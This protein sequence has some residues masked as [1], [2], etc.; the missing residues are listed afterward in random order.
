MTRGGEPI[1]LSPTEYRL[2]H[3]LLLN[4]RPGAD[5]GADPGPRVGLRLRG[6]G[7]VVDTYISYLRRKVDMREPRLIQ[8]VRGVGFTLRVEP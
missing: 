8:T 2:L 6:R 7:S 5:P 3:Y 1:H 4:A